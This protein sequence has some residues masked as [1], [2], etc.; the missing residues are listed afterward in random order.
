[1]LRPDLVENI[2]DL[3]IQMTLGAV[4]A[5]H[6]PRGRNGPHDIVVHRRLGPSSFSRGID[7]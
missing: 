5:F 6:F 2:K 3:G 1:M 7:F 4:M